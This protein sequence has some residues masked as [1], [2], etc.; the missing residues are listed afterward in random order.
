MSS[1]KAN[2]PESSHIAEELLASGPSAIERRC[3]VIRELLSEGRFSLP[4]LLD[5][6]EVRMEDYIQ[7]ASHYM[8]STM[9]SLIGPVPSQ[10][11]RFLLGILLALNHDLLITWDGNFQTIERHFKKLGKDSGFQLK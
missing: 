1:K 8:T 4:Q 2:I 3:L 9:M 10:D 5:M 7:F 11:N 6:Y